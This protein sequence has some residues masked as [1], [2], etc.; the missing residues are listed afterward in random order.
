MKNINLQ[1]LK[2]GG[3][4]LIGKQ[5]AELMA[6]IENSKSPNIPPSLISQS[7]AEKELIKQAANASNE[8]SQREVNKKINANRR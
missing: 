8:Y 5:L 1:N 7:K 4:E 3:A 6:K 2:F